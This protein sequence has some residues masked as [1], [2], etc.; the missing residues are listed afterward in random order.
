MPRRR[1]DEAPLAFTSNGR[2]LVN[3]LAQL[4]E[5]QAATLRRALP[6]ELGADWFIG[7][8]VDQAS[9][10]A[11][12]ARL[13]D[14]AAETAARLLATAAKSRPKSPS[15]PARPRRKRPGRP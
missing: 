8:A 13:D 10:R 12:F 4:S 7:L 2:L 15:K 14:A 11:A 6:V 1:A 5:E 9:S 3:V